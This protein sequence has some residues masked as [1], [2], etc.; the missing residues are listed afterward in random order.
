M[1][2]LTMLV[3]TDLSAQLHRPEVKFK[4]DESSSTIMVSVDGE[5]FTTYHYSDDLEKPLLYPLIT[6]SGTELTRGYP[7]APRPGERVD[8]PHH[9]GL[10]LNYGNVNGLDFW[11]NSKHINPEKKA[12][13]GKI[14]HQEILKMEDGATGDL[15][16]TAQ[17]VNADG[18]PLLNEQT[19]YRFSQLGKLRIIDRSTTLTALEDVDMHDNKEGML[20][21]RVARQLELPDDRPQYL[22]DASGRRTE[23]KVVNNEGVNG[24]YLSSNGKEGDDVWGTRGTW[25]KMYGKIAD[26][27]VSITIID[28]P[29]NPGYP[30]Y[31]HARGYGLFAANPLGQSAFSKKKVVLNFSL[32]KGESAN[33]KYRILLHGGG[34]ISKEAIKELEKKFATM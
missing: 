22:V 21:V 5:D 32:K 8:H 23:E 25:V 16:V 20:G 12:H 13:Y 26:D 15:V 7:I 31:W 29:E 24:N 17:W 27:P 6:T 2:L 10:W 34:T 1:L 9:M 14:V 30:T 28:H 3:S 18:D 11:N 4:H 19:A 33:F